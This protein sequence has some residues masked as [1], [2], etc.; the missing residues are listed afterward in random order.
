M[1]LA[2]AVA[3]RAMGEQWIAAARGPQSSALLFEDGSALAMADNED[4]RDPQWMD[5]PFFVQFHS[6]VVPATRTGAPLQPCPPSS[7][8]D[9]FIPDDFYLEY[10]LA[11]DGGRGAR[12]LGAMRPWWEMIM[13]STCEPLYVVGNKQLPLTPALQRQITSLYVFYFAEPTATTPRDADP[14]LQKERRMAEHRKKEQKYDFMMD[15]FS[16]LEGGHWS[17][18]FFFFSYIGS[19]ILRYCVNSGAHYHKSIQN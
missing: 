3:A 14:I 12:R 8:F 7:F 10:L 2:V 15:L 17:L 9:L 5:I 16:W 13:R 4:D 11:P 6:P 1:F 18:F 19:S